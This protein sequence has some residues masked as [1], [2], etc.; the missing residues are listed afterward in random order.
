MEQMKYLHKIY[1]CTV[2]DDYLDI[3]PV[4]ADKVGKVATLDGDHLSGRHAS[5]QALPTIK[6]ASCG[7]GWE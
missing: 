1:Y 2:M 5:A 7:W 6:R 4:S 3:P